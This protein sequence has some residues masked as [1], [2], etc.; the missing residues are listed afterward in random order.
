MAS[1]PRASA[2]IAANARG[3][4]L[5][6]LLVVVATIALLIAVL[7]PALS[8]A[9]S[10]AKVASCKANLK[11]VGTMAETYRTDCRG[12]VPVMFNY[13]QGSV[14]RMPARTALLS[15]ALRGYD[16]RRGRLPA[17]FNPE[18]VWLD[19]KRAEYERTWLA[20]YY[21]CPFVRDGAAGESVVGTTSVWG[22]KYT[23]TYTLVERRGRYETCHTWLWEDIVRGEIPREKHPNDPR[24]GRPKYSV[25]SWNKVAVG[26]AATADIPGG[27]TLREALDDP[28]K[29]TM[30]A[31]LHRCWN[32]ADARR[33]K[34]AS[35]AELTTIYCAQGN[36]LELGRVVV[37]PNSHRMSAG[38]GTNVVFAD[39]HVEWV[40]GTQVGWP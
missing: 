29:R 9:R 37:N 38:G 16:T 5:I 30:L 22:P 6:E 33:R 19:D 39:S 18:D 20:S 7:I 36:H 31:N 23:A 11:Q 10:Q 14:Y 17:A 35:L 26:A 13:Y 25:L 1:T 24:E 3:F 27:I 32:A 40:R 28:G 12:F 34:S 15:V 8:Q 2:A 4:T 21:V